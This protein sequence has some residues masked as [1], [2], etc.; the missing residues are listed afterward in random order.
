M[1][2]E[3]TD[4]LRFRQGRWK[5]WLFVGLLAG[6]A[7]S[8][9]ILPR[10]VAIWIFV[11]LALTFPV[12]MLYIGVPW[13]VNRIDAVLA[14]LA[15]RLTITQR[16]QCGRWLARLALILTICAAVALLPGTESPVVG[17]GLL[18]WLAALV[19]LGVGLW[20]WP[21]P[22]PVLQRRDLAAGK[23]AGIVRWPLLIGA[24]LALMLLAEING[25]RFQHIIALTLPFHIQFALLVVGCIFIVLAFGGIRRPASRTRSDLWP[26][27]GLVLLAFVLN[28]WQLSTAVHAFV[29]EFHSVHALDKLWQDPN[30]LLLRPYEGV[31]AF[32]AVYTYLQ[33]I[34]TTILGPNL[35]GLRLASVMLGTLLVPA[36]YLLAHELFDRPTALLAALLLATFPPFIHFS[37][38]GINNIA[39]PLFGVLA[40]AFLVRGL[41]YGRWGDYALSGVMLGLTQYF[42]EGGKLLYPPLVLGW[43]VLIMWFWRPWRQWRGLLVFL[44]AFLMVAF[45][46]YYLSLAGEVSF[47]PR[48]QAINTFQSYFLPLIRLGLGPFLAE[49]YLPHL[50]HFINRPDNSGFFYSDQVALVLSHLVPFFML[51]VGVALAR[52][53]LVG[54]LLILWLAGTIFGNSLV[55]FASSTPRFVLAFPLV[56]LLLAVGIRHVLPLIVPE[57]MP[58]WWS[59]R[60]WRSAVMLTGL[61]LLTVPSVAFYFGPNMVDY[62]RLLRSQSKDIVDVMY[63]LRDLPPDAQ[64][65]ILH[66]NEQFLYQ[67]RVSDVTTWWGDL[68][69]LHMEKSTDT[70]RKELANLPLNTTIAVFLD[71]DDS[72]ALEILRER[73]GTLPQPQYSPYSSVPP[74]GQYILFLIEADGLGR[75]PL[76]DG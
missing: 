22:L 2:T 10:V 55:F 76:T 4:K 54:V 1:Q 71:P 62:N 39:D 72:E 48:L 58:A 44:L 47:T 65:Y 13:V 14:R 5:E 50:L 34:A 49:T 66:L 35:A 7:I 31:P 53:R 36:V 69:D 16:V 41:K 9:I 61:L 11:L 6:L 52:L 15:E 19:S 32:T 57:Q 3:H 33:M 30:Y 64:I 20:L 73:F 40:L 21:R 46:I 17:I 43:L 29:D 38:L 8:L 59:N 45:P 42:Y 68:P 74:D 70:T 67:Q 60:R 18:L 75:G 12:I 51:G 37:R 56:A 23:S 63:R 26:L 24:A 28:T 27:V 25:H